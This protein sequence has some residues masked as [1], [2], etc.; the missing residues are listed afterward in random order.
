MDFPY[1]IKFEYITWRDK[2]W[3][4]TIKVDKA[5]SVQRVVEEALLVWH[6]IAPNGRLS[7]DIIARIYSDPE[8]TDL[9]DTAT[10]SKTS[11]EDFKYIINI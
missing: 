1:Y 11:K 8:T 10:W 4:G 5:D 6:N 3:T 7:G 2:I 9:L